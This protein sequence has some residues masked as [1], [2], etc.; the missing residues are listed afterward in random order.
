[1]SETKDFAPQH[2]NNIANTKDLLCYN[3]IAQNEGVNGGR[4]VPVLLSRGGGISGIDHTRRY[5]RL[6]SAL[7]INSYPN[8]ANP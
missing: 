7:E 6:Y 8:D 4:C 2:E 1:M 3:K 5:L